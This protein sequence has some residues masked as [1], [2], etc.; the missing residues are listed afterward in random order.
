VLTAIFATLQDVP[1]RLCHRCHSDLPAEDSGALT[2]CVHC[3]A[4]QVLLS[5]ELRDQFERQQSA[6]QPPSAG[7]EDSALPLE[8]VTDP[9][10]VQ[11][12]RALQLV[13]LAGALFAL[14]LLLGKAI[15]PVGL[16]S[17]L[18]LMGAPIIVLGVYCA[19]NPAS[20][21]TAGFGA[22]LG[23]LSGVSIGLAGLL[24]FT[25]SL[26]V[27]RFVLHQGG[28]FDQQI[29]QQIAEAVSKVSATP[30]AASP[31]AVADVA[32][33]KNAMAI[34]AFR[35]GVFLGGCLLSVSFYAIYCSIAGAFS[36]YLRARARRAIN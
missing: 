8:A 18:W 7:T 5:E 11:W 24:L 1:V 14:L 17:L 33:M 13:A 12:P 20:R 25:A 16:V 28:V 36:G 4:P 22:R 29:A 21:V 2:F 27:T 30:D 34:P 19:R 32:N 23:L 15:P 31:D 6:A 35:A 26:L 3:G 9:T 10:A